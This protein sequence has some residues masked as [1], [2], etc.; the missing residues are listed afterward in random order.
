[1]TKAII[2]KTAIFK[3]H[4]RSASK[5][6]A[7]DE[8][9][10]LYSKAYNNLLEK[11]KPL[12]EAWL[13][14]EKT[15]SRFDA[16]KQIS[17][18]CDS[19]TE[20]GLSSKL[21]EGLIADIAGNIIS[22]VE[23]EKAYCSKEHDSDKGEP[24]YPKPDYSYQPSSY[25][26][27]LDSAESW[28]GTNQE[29]LSLLERTSRQQGRPLYFCRLRDFQLSEYEPN[30]WGVTLQL[31]NKFAEQTKYRFP[32]AF[33]DWHVE[34][35]LRCAKPRCT[36]L[37][38][39]DGEYFLHVAFEFEREILDKG[40]EESYLGIDRGLRKQAC[41]AVVDKQGKVLETGALG[42][43]VADLQRTLGRNRQEKQQKGCRTNRKDYQRNQQEKMLHLIANELIDKA[44]K[45]KSLVVME[46]LNVQNTNSRTRSLYAKFKKILDYKLPLNGMWQSKEVFAAY[47]SKICSNCGQEG[48]REAE[49]FS[50]LACGYA[51]DADINAAINIARRALYKK[52]DWEKKGGYKV[53]H[54][55]F[56]TAEIV[57]YLPAGPRPAAK[58]YEGEIP[59]VC[60]GQIL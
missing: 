19:V 18:A 56:G 24:Q 15:P 47:S 2:Q 36:H 34:N 14:V 46:D 33:G 32:L 21:R 10:R 54:Q 57:G 23:L 60:G 25:E 44:V 45:H 8:A 30:R 26:E 28:I 17:R 12:A 40:T 43:E 20:I 11:C 50:C 52:A 16:M 42:A 59:L 49:S 13:I 3:L 39:V 53:F 41:Y 4:F 22:Y 5:T 38:R 31:F 29:F 1:M 6:R 35:Y 58:P 27:A 37:C 55:S 7:L 51:G 48:I 9:I